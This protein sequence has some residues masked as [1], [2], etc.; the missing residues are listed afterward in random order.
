MK[1]N[2]TEF[3]NYFLHLPSILPEHKIPT[4][5]PSTPI[6]LLKHLPRASSLDTPPAPSS[7]AGGEQTNAVGEQVQV[8]EMKNKRRWR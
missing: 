1:Q 7:N 5:S 2:Y 8:A 6:A 4:L 3:P